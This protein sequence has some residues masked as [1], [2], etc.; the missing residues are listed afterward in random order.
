MHLSEPL[1][2]RITPNVFELDGVQYLIR[3]E[4]LDASAVLIS[5]DDFGIH[6]STSDGEH[7]WPVTS[8][9]APQVPRTSN[10]LSIPSWIS[11]VHPCVCAGCHWLESIDF[12]ADAR[13]RQISGFQGCG[14]FCS[15]IPASVEIVT[16]TGFADCSSLEIVKFEKNSSLREID[17]F[18][19]CPILEIQIPSSV[20][21]VGP[22]D[23]QSCRSLKRVKFAQTSHLCAIKGFCA[24]ARG[25]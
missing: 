9:E 21:R 18:Y 17:G 22:S 25:L 11:S 4:S 13:L 23:F 6:E 20:E 14:I 3:T 12:V 5:H 16:K 19:R 15:T 7:S 1:P 2:L 10:S 8:L 24:I